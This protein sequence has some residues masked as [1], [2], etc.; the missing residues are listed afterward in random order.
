MPLV[1][2]VVFLILLIDSK[3]A[4][5]CLDEVGIFLL[6][7]L[8]DVLSLNGRTVFLCVVENMMRG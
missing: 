4:V 7:L 3:T 2:A 8:I 5:F 1:F 6:I